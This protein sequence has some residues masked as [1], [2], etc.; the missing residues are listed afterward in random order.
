MSPP[1]WLPP[2]FEF[3]GDWPL[4]LKALYELFKA[5][6]IDTKPQFRGRTLGLK[7]YPM[8]D[9]KEVTF[10]HM[11]QEGPVEE[12]RLPDLR[13]CERIRWPRPIIENSEDQL[14]KVWTNVRKGEVRF[15]LW[16]EVEEYLVVLA[17]RKGYLLP[18][19]AYL[20]TEEHRKRK[21]L[22]EFEDWQKEQG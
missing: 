2:L 14:L 3:R 7:R 5:D 13:R 21:L 11:I 18:W 16:L 10:W 1:E 9:G 17:E 4:Y 20:V 12:G 22:K 19:T 6:F 15:L 8:S